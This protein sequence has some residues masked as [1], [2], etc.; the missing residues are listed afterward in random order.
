MSQQRHYANTI[1]PLMTAFPPVSPT[2]GTYSYMPDLPTFV[3]CRG[4]ECA[5][6]FDT[7][8]PV[9]PRQGQCGYGANTPTLSSEAHS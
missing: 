1:C 5:L 7:S 9:G 6:W 3:Y 4:P 8:A 2:S